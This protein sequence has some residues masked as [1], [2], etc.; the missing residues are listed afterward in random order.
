MLPFVEYKISNGNERN[1]EKEKR[2]SKIFY[3]G[4]SLK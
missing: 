3:M 4:M 2:R 1:I